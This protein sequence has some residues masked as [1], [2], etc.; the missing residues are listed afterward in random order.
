ML[1]IKLVLG[2]YIGGLV[3]LTLDLVSGDELE[4][5]SSSLNELSMSLPCIRIPSSLMM[6]T[7]WLLSSLD[8][9]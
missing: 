8:G 2:F 1:F 9:F 4:E 6:L 5:L 7:L 3:E